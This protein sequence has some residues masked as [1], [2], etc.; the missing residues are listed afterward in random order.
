VN[1]KYTAK[2]SEGESIPEYKKKIV[3]EHVPSEA[4]FLSYS[5]L[6]TKFQVL[7]KSSQIHSVF[8]VASPGCH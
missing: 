3:Y 8:I 4:W 2:H 5:L 7:Y 6:R 1:E